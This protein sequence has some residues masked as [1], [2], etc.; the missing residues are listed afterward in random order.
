MSR[1]LVNSPGA[2]GVSLNVRKSA[3]EGESICVYA[4]FHNLQLL[5]S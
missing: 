3:D 2:G 1:E 5:L 4:G